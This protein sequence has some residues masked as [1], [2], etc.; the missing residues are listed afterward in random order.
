MNMFELEKV[1]MNDS[2]DEHLSNKQF[3]HGYK[4]LVLIDGAFCLTHLTV[5]LA[6]TLVQCQ[7]SVGQGIP[8]DHHTI[9]SLT[10]SQPVV[11]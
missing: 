8:V 10:A 7:C 9:N 5:L 11:V 3:W 4:R 1:Y 2:T 6:L